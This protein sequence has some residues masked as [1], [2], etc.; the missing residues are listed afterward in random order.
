M[1]ARTF[2]DWAARMATRRLPYPPPVPLKRDG[3]E[4]W[5]GPLADG[6]AAVLLLNRGKEPADITA[7]WDD[8]GAPR[9]RAV[10][11]SHRQAAPTSALHAC[12]PRSSMPRFAPWCA[13]LS[14]ANAMS[15][16]D[17]WK[18]AELGIFTESFTATAV[19][20]HGVVRVF[21]GDGVL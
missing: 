15:A 5:A 9:F 10:F 3:Q 20:S 2:V 8:L 21:G 7:R 12:L 18:K 1:H 6:S 4:V 16:R 17:L 11:V 19:P 14:P 13:G